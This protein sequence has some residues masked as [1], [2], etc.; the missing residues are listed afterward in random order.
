MELADPDTAAHLVVQ[1]TEALTHRYAHQGIH[2]LPRDRFI[3]EVVALL[4]RYLTP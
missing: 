3:A 1:T 4:T 2:D